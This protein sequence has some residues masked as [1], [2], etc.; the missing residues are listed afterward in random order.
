MRKIFADAE[1][2]GLADGDTVTLTLLNKIGQELT[3]TYENKLISFKKN[4]AIENNKLEVE[5]YENDKT[6][7][8]SLYLLNIKGINFRFKINSSKENKPHELTSLLQL[9]SNDE[10]AYFENEKL[11][12]EDAFVKKM[13]LKFSNKEPYFTDNQNRVFEY[14]IFYANYIYGQDTTIDVEEAL[15]KFLGEIIWQ[16]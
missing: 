9:G 7:P 4:I 13:E 5:L 16:K 11:I 15:D 14:F 8:L 6:F 12:F 1:L 3:T 10:V 2:F